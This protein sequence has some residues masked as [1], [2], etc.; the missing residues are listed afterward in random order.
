MTIETFTFSPFKTNCYVAHD[1]G[2]AVIVDASCYA[3]EE[4]QEV[5]DYL[6]RHDLT[7]EYLLLTHA[8]VDHIL[9]CTFLSERYDMVWDMH[10]ADVDFIERAEEQ[11]MAFGVELEAA[12]RPGT[13]LEEGDVVSFGGVRWEVLHTPGHSPGSISFYDAENRIVV[14][15]DVLFQGSVGRMDLPGGSQEQLMKSIA[16][17]LLP[18]GDDVTVYPGHGPATTMERERTTNPFLMGKVSGP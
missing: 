9:G 2:E 5:V 6:E 1:D 14:A 15:G 10:E 8:H 3:D 7:V 11:A 18:L 16:Q 12:P 13:F 17:K 4:R